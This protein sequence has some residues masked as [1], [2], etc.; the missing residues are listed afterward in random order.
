MS[1]NSHH[2]DRN[3]DHM[4]GVFPVIKTFTQINGHTQGLSEAGWEHR[5]SLSL[6]WESAWHPL[7]TVGIDLTSCRDLPR[8]HK[9]L[10]AWMWQVSWL[11]P[12]PGRPFSPCVTSGKWGYSRLHS[13]MIKFGLVGWLW[14]LNLLLYT[15]DLGLC[16]GYKQQSLPLAKPML[17][18]YCLRWVSLWTSFHGRAKR[19]A[20]LLGRL[21]GMG[22]KLP[23]NGIRWSRVVIRNW[24]ISADNSAIRILLTVM[25]IQKA[26]SRAPQSEFT[27]WVSREEPQRRL[28]KY[29]QNYL[30]EYIVGLSKRKQRGNGVAWPSRIHLP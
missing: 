1:S 22:V 3:A 23:C 2:C 29:H 16:L 21:I 27:A 4:L 10:Q 5:L 26:T 12:R 17:S 11:S 9:W 15:K 19:S 7:L 6:C 13:L 24:P 18:V 14:E 30:L 20:L 8:Q 28:E 25:S